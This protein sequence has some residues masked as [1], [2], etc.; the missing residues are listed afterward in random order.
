MLPRPSAFTSCPVRTALRLTGAVHV[1]DDGVEPFAVLGSQL[2]EQA[3]AIAGALQD[4][5]LASAEHLRTRERRVDAMTASRDPRPQGHLDG[6]LDVL[7]VQLEGPGATA[8]DGAFSAPPTRFASSQEVLL[9]CGLSLGYP[10]VPDAG[11]LTRLDKQRLAP[12]CPFE[13]PAP[14][15][16]AVAIGSP[17]ASHRGLRS[18]QELVPSLVVVEKIDPAVLVDPA[19]LFLAFGFRPCY[20]E[21]S[22]FYS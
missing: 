3:D 2:T 11:S 10:P 19:V 1:L 20:C 9:G 13:R 16:G 18:P 15:L 17:G 22:R 21:L 5:K 14:N 8:V 4:A 6:D 12:P 7:A